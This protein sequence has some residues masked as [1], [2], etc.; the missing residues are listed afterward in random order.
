MLKF[1]VLLLLFSKKTVQSAFNLKGT[2]NYCEKCWDECE[3]FFH[4]D[5]CSKCTQKCGTNP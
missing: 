2:S 5:F 1:I 4:D 3:T